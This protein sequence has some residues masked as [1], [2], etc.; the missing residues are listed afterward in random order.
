MSKKK[1]TKFEEMLAKSKAE[2][3]KE[4][5]APT[6]AI[7]QSQLDELLKEV[8]TVTNA[9]AQA[10][11]SEIVQA[12]APVVVEEDLGGYADKQKKEAA[13]NL[14]REVLHPDAKK[15]Y[16]IWFD[17]VNRTYFMDVIEYENGEIINFRSE[18]LTTS[19]AMALAKVKEIFTHKL[20]IRRGG[21]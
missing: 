17:S 8:E 6:P 10:L 7:P 20:I 1:S 9:V 5:V 14:L 15:A 16:N 4:I 12:S 13:E 21:V 2:K 3:A 19:Q 11:E 18:R